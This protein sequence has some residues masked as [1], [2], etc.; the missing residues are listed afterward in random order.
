MTELAYIGL[1][2]CCGIVGWRYYGPT[3]RGHASRNQIRAQLSAAA[4]R[5][6]AQWT[7]PCLTKAELRSV[8]LTEIA[9]PLHRGPIGPMWVPF[10]NPTGTIAP[11]QSGKTR[12]DLI[13]K[14]LDAPGALLCSTTKADLI[15]MAGLARGRRRNAG[16]V[17]VYDATGTVQ[18]PA[19]L[20][21]SPII[22]CHDPATAYRRARAMVEASAVTVESGGGGGAGN[23]RIFRDRATMVLSAYFVAAALSG[24][25]MSE[26]LR[27][28]TEK[29]LTTEAA[30]LLDAYYPDLAANLRAETGMVARTADAV[31]MSVRRVI[32]PLT[33][34][35]CWRCAALRP[36]ED[37][38]RCNSFATTDRCS[39]SR[40]NT[41]PRKSCHS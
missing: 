41:R 13:H 40:G 22:G 38:T 11:T 36:A 29:P 1:A 8:A 2:A 10:E 19:Q 25:P 26:V 7:R 17:L 5:R 14:A 32:E 3:P 27:W 28:A 21:W 12:R 24:R 9:A 4:A 31:W 33:N 37:W 23:D 34:P 39:S 30:G 16:P 35:L 18:W 20:R 15:E 6:T